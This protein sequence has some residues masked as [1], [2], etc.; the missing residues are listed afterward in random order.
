M[1]G[2]LLDKFDVVV[3]FFLLP[4]ARVFFFFIPGF[5]TA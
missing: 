4:R 1:L 2:L 5:S 3:D